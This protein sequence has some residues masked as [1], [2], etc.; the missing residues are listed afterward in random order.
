MVDLRQELLAVFDA[1]YRDHLRVI[2]DLL[3]AGGGTRRALAEIFRRMHPLKGGA[4]AVES[5]EVE[6]IAHA[7]ENRLSILME[8][9][10]SLD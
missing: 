3:K 8:R 10:G 4:R 5:P 9:G 1:E 2:R 6:D 7:V